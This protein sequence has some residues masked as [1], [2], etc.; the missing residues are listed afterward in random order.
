MPD[1]LSVFSFA[2]ASE[3][4]GRTISKIFNSFYTAFGKAWR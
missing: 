2:P 4:I 1:R 3:I